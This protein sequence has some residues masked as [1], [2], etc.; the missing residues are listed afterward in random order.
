MSEDRPPDHKHPVS[1]YETTLSG[2]GR[3]PVVRARVEPAFDRQTLKQSLQAEGQLIAFGQGRSY[4]DSALSARV[5]DMRPLDRMLSFDASDGLLVCEAGVLLADVIGTFL[6]RGWFLRVTPGTK[7]TTIGGAI[8]ADVHGKNHHKAGCFGTWVKWIDLMLADGS[9]VRCSTGQ[10]TELF[11]ATCG[12]MGLTGIIIQAGIL[13]QPVPSA[14]IRQTT[15]KTRDLAGT[16]EAF[17][18]HHDAPYSVAWIDC[19]SGGSNLGR[20]LIMLGDFAGPGDAAGESGQTETRRA[21]SQRKRTIDY[22]PPGQGVR[23]PDAFPGSL[24]NRRTISLFNALYYRKAPQGQSSG[25]VGLDSFFYPLDRL[26]N[27]NRIYGR[28]G[29]IQYQFILPKET[30]F[31]GMEEILAEIT[32]SRMG[33]FLAVLK[34]YGPEN[35]HYLSFPMEGYSLALD[36]KIQNGLQDLFDRLDRLVIKYNGRVYLAKDAR[37]SRRMFDRGYPR[38][39]RFRKLRKALGLDKKFQSMQSLRLGL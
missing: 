29:M 4:G 5:A 33:S 12:G 21:P 28:S 27:W 32:K 16:F 19:I 26:R 36:F 7:Y 24:L 38:A 18:T 22:T 23:I 15:V 35:D 6:P 13:L 2:W 17:E 14:S 39:D 30:S 25:N 37:M 34:L 10:E 11:H 20:S 31:N 9:V 8:A 1:G 3:H